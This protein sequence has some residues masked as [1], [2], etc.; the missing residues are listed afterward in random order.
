MTYATRLSRSGAVEIVTPRFVVGCDLAQ[1]ADFTAFSFIEVTGAP[2]V[3][4][5]RHLDRFRGEPYTA[6]AR[7]LAGLVDRLLAQA[8]RPN[9]EVVVDATG[10]GAAALDVMR[11]ANINAPLIPVLIHGGD[12]VSAEGGTYRVPKRDL[13]AAVQVAMEAKRLKINPDLPF[14]TVLT[15]ELAKFRKKT[16]KTGHD[17]Y[18]SWRDD[19]HDDAVLSVSLAVWW[20]EH[21]QGARFENVHDHPL[22]VEA[23]MEL[24]L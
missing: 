5:V 12:R 18:E 24:G 14:A 2:A 1:S 10:V 23:L 20:G 3:Y 4:A 9:V 11:E 6:V 17:S 15:D 7:K 22:L 19:D 16:T 8:P 13:I 21:R